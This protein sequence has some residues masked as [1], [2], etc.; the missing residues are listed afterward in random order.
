MT[1]LS[2]RSF[3]ASAMAS[4]S[5][6]ALPARASEAPPFSRNTVIS[7]A[8]DLAARDYAPR[9]SVPQDWLDMSY[10]A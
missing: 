7:K 5:M 4:T 9:P 2:R 3:L 6:I 8:H 1:S 10:Q